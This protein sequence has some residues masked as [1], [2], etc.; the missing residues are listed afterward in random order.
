MEIFGTTSLCYV[1]QYVGKRRGAEN[2]EARKSRYSR[3]GTS[4]DN[5]VV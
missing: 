4:Y 1:N 2:T 3:T 5:A